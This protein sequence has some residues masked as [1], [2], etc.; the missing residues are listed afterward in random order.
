M[1][2]TLDSTA[3]DIDETSIR[4][5][6]A[7]A[8]ALDPVRVREILAKGR[9]L[10]GLDAGDIVPLM[11]LDDPELIAEL[12][13]T[14]RYVKDTIY[15]RRLVIFAPLYV[16]NLCANEC[17]YCAFRVHNKE[18]VRRALTQEEIARETR[19]LIDQG[20]KRVLV[21]AGEAYP[22]GGLQYILDAIET[23]YAVKSG[24]GEVRRINVNIA[25]LSTEDFVRLKAARIGTYQIF[26]ETYHHATYASVHVSGKKADYH[27]RL[28]AVDRAMSAGIDDCGIGVLFGL[29][30]WRFEMLAL[31][32]HI[33]HLESAFGVG[34]HTLSVPRIEPATGS[35]MAER[36]PSPVD[37]QSFRKIVAILRIA[38]PY[39]GIIMSTRETAEM[40]SETFALGVSQISGGSRT[41]PGGYAESARYDTSQFS[42]GDHRELD[43]VVCDVAKLGY[44]PSFCTACYRM[45]RTGADFM[46]LARPGEI[47]KH[48]GPNAAASFQEYLMDYG[49]D[50]ACSAGDSAIEASIA[51]MDEA[52]ARHSRI[53]VSKVKEGKR[54]VYR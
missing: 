32:Q 37:D 16:S 36:P 15:G 19:V 33:R 17:L 12:F 14:A 28:S 35:A 53:M 21:V 34:P 11:A 48:C 49:S 51:D 23:I 25:P 3:F 46:D 18:V 31:M 13:E 5:S 1:S 10:R 40:R 47:K 54:D 29:Y 43:E 20:H 24:N 30:D 26:Q 7:G 52:P 39:T 50:E 22:K 44:V 4:N 8:S 9:E 6:L 42:L 2:A 45:G 27:Y 38:V 41:N